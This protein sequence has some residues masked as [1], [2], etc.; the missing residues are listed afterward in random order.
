MP[1]KILVAIDKCLIL[2]IDRLIENTMMI[3]KTNN[4]KKER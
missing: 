2:V 1:T 4:W 3:H